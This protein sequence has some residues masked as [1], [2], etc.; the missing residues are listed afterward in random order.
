MKTYKGFN[1]NIIHYFKDKKLELESKFR[2]GSDEWW[3]ER[4]KLE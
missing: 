1:M 3:E 4:Q 2:G